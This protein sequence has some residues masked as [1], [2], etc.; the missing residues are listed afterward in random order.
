MVLASLNDLLEKPFKSYSKEEQLEIVQN[1]RFTDLTNIC[2]NDKGKYR[3][4]AVSWY[5]RV[6]WLSGN[7]VNKKLYCWHCVLYPSGNFK[8]WNSTGF[9]DLK[10]LSQSVRKHE[11]S[12]E[13]TYSTVK[14]K[15]L[16]NKKRSQENARKQLE[17]NVKVKRN[18][19]YLERLIDV[20]SA[21]AR[22]NIPFQKDVEEGF[23]KYLITVLK[24][25]DDIVRTQIEVSSPFKGLTRTIQLDLI[26][27]IAHTVRQRIVHELDSVKFF[28]LQ[29]DEVNCLRGRQI[30]V[31]L[32][33]VKNA[34][35]VERFIGFFDVGF[36]K[37]ADEVV[38]ILE[39]EL[40]RF[41]YKEK[42]IAQCFDGGVV[43][44]TEIYELQQ[45]VKKLVGSPNRCQFVHCYAYEFSDIL[46]QSLRA[47]QECKLFFTMISMFSAFFRN[48]LLGEVVQN[49]DLSWTES[50]FACIKYLK[51]NDTSVTQILEYLNIAD[52]FANVPHIISD[53]VNLINHLKSYKFMVFIN[54]F[55][56]IFSMIEDSL[57]KIKNQE[58]SAIKYRDEINSLTTK[59][60]Q[61]KS[62]SK[63]NDIFKNVQH[64]S[65]QQV[66]LKNMLD[67][68][69][70]IIDHIIY[71]I[72]G[73]FLDIELLEF[74]S[75]V[76]AHSMPK[77]SDPKSSKIPDCWAMIKE[78][79]Q[80]YFDNAK[81]K[82]ELELLYNDST[83][84]GIGEAG[85]KTP[86]DMLKFLYDHE[87]NTSLPML[88]RL[89]ELVV[90]I[91]SFT[92]PLRGK[93]CVLNR[94]KDY[95]KLEK[96]EEPRSAFA[97]LAIEKDMFLEA[98][99]SSHW[100][101]EIIDYFAT[102]PSTSS[103]E[104]VYKNGETSGHGK[105]NKTELISE[106]E[107]SIKQESDM[108]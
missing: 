74:A 24:K 106:P 59:L 19:E 95:C 78:N 52:E 94:I 3:M 53:C 96:F 71:E 57:E 66:I 89:L 20:A 47:I 6:K 84:G 73:R 2:Q 42:M 86:R 91:P 76:S 69:L 39:R 51:D 82:T 16:L 64:V 14:L 33:Y 27:S 49:I 85:V 60:K 87:V 100:Y 105:T 63:F 77:P 21:L 102:L 34:E 18:R 46:A 9:D 83:I 35:P 32:R 80:N 108:L 75:L 28:A 10:N 38:G 45:S 11:E 36:N 31:S 107:L 61:L 5:Q 92:W 50:T 17:D 72:D 88:Y 26:E 101:D 30:A 48:P 62:E 97:L 44:S 81:L 4:F 8:I 12:R 67:L 98:E 79:Y 29:V 58:M 68:Y 93:A 55:H 15:L 104:L 23:Y 1:G 99:Q 13:H 43:K 25:Y 22:F 37:K 40:E 56:N 70:E 103:I 7:T 54:M 65:G 41:N 90:T